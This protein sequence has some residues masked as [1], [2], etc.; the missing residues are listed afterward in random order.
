MGKKKSEKTLCFYCGCLVSGRV[1]Y[2]HFPIPAE[3]GG[4]ETV[5]ACISCNDMKDRF[6]LEEWPMAW[7]AKVAE[8]F[9]KMSRETRLFL[10]KMTRLAAVHIHKQA[11]KELKT[12]V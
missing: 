6:V 11:Q 4:V 3:C 12:A 8:D 5:P 2:D 10:A 1:E 9:P 7:A